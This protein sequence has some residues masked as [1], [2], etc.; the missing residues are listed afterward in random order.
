MALDNR[1]AA[2]KLSGPDR[3]TPDK[4]FVPVSC[5]TADPR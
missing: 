2:D 4:A 3:K 5:E 1:T